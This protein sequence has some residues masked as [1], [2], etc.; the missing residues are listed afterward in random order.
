MSGKPQENRRTWVGDTHHEAGSGE[1]AAGRE[2]PTIV[3]PRGSR[4]VPCLPGLEDTHYRILSEIGRGGM[5]VVYLARDIKLGR[6]VAIKRL[7]PEFLTDNAMRGR[8]RREAQLI[9]ALNH[10]Y[11][12]KLYDFDIERADPRIIMEYV[13]GPGKPPA[14]DWPAPSLNLEQKLDQNG[15]PLTLR[16]SVILVRK[17]CAAMEYAHRNGV[18]HRDLKPSNILLDEHGEPRIVDFG[19][20]RQMVADND[21][22][23]MTGA[24]MLSLGYAAPEQE[25]APAT[26]DSRADVYS[27]GGILYFCLTGE[28]PR[29]FR[30]NRVPEPLRPMI[31]KAM[32]RDPEQRW[33]SARD[34]ADVLS[35]SA[36]DLISP[37][38][39]P[40]MWRCKWCNSLNPV[41]N[42][43]CAQCNWDG[44]ESCPE[45]GA[46]TRVGVRFC[47]R[48]S[49]DIKSFEDMRALLLRLREYRR[50]KDFQR[51]KDA[52]DG[53]SRFQPRGDK[54]R[55]IAREIHELA[56]TA[57]WAIS[58]KEEL[59]QAIS[60]G[61][62][63][64]NYED[65]QDRLN[66][67]GV[68]D[69][70][71][72]YTDLRREL[73]WRIAERNIVLLRGDLVEARRMLAARRPGEAARRIADIENR[74]LSLAQLESR[75]PPLQGALTAESD[76]AGASAA[77]SYGRVVASLWKDVE[78]AKADAEAARQAVERM[79]QSASLAFKA[80]DY[81][82]CRKTCEALREVTIEPSQAE[83][84]VEKATERMMQIDRMLARADDAIR[85][86]NL[87]SAERS[88]R[89]L[90]DRLKQD[91]RPARQRL[92]R[93]RRVRRN[94]TLAAWVVGLLV[95]VILYVF[96]IGPV[97]RAAMREGGMQAA[98]RRESLDSLYA[99]VFWLHRET[100]LGPFLESYAARWQVPVFR[101]RER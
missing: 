24:R 53:V 75:F 92:D 21:K 17:L 69:D 85:R 13:T 3:I 77:N 9:A 14:P 89:D 61:L 36:G 50:T 56:E 68:L 49:T 39:D 4:P 34:F 66:E 51:I 41:A 67:Y 47:G 12:V 35:Q 33:A 46:E 40:G 22:L 101:R 18:I 19:I 79:L 80:Q 25:T 78:Q 73:P 38:T 95:G 72:G 93:I 63:R 45:C 48:C 82:G 57:T 64:Q 60:A 55:E 91:C 65:V 100:P 2:T 44:M 20:A 27:L 90:L 70:G 23:T 10:I 74:L 71:P 42:R 84:L 30:D 87:K 96:S 32:E 15:A 54:G 31:L 1:S 59:V 97:Y 86:G 43:Y 94:R 52:M 58:R 88:M 83:S 62:D 37:L 28:N 7:N 26:A 11:I 16:A 76:G 98:Q 6:Y 81:E 8:F 29:F 5:S 99:P